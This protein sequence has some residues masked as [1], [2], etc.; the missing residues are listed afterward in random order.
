MRHPSGRGTGLLI[1]PGTLSRSGRLIIMEA[2]ER[3]RPPGEP[4]SDDLSTVQRVQAGDMAGFADLVAKYQDRVFNTCWRIC[5]HLEDARDL[6]QEAFLKALKSIGSFRA[7]SGFYTWLFRIAVNLAVSHRRR[8]GYRAAQS[9]DSSGDGMASAGGL[10]LVVPE[11]AGA[12]MER[13]ELHSLVVNAIQA[14]DTDQRA[15]V[16]LRD[17]EG[18]DY[19]QI[20]EL[21]DISPGTVKSRLHRARCA[22]RKTLA[23]AIEPKVEEDGLS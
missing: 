18:M 19:R 6:T 7:E 10:R 21:L 23:P 20:G 9:L 16:V 2:A 11:E 5:G 3:S 14:L 12:K 17:V 13:R 1:R 8:E 15:V 4:E 22:L